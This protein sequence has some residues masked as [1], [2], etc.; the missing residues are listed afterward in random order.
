MRYSFSIRSVGPCIAVLFAALLAAA[1]PALA[2][3]VY[4]HDCAQ[5]IWT[6]PLTATRNVDLA[7][8]APTG[9]PAHFAQ[10]LN[11][12]CSGDYQR[13]I[14][15]QIDAARAALAA[16]KASAHGGDKPALVLDIDET[17]L[18]NE[19]QI[20][21]GG[22]RNPSSGAIDPC[23]DPPSGCGYTTW[24]RMAKGTAIRPTLELFREALKDGV[25]VFMITGRN[26]D[27]APAGGVSMRDATGTNLKNE[28]YVGYTCLFLQQHGE[29][30]VDPDWHLCPALQRPADFPSTSPGTAKFKEAVRNA[31]VAAGYTIVI[32]V[33]DQVSDLTG[34]NDINHIHDGPAKASF[35]LPNPFY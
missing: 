23:N 1:D 15:I 30:T 27:Q 29:G 10:L 18:S 35:L 3:D 34:T 22:F 20:L 6:E 33:G 28:G 13:D 5:A 26:E 7:S 17:S 19:P 8:I 24:E 25:S 21:G 14:A 2:A 9:R 32:N 31:I 16:W 11:Y 4:D 12:L